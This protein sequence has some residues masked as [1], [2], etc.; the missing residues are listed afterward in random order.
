MPLPKRD[1][2]GRKATISMM[3][4][5]SKPGEVIDNATHG[6]SITIEKNGKAAAV[7]APSDPN[8][9]CTVI[10]GDGTIEGAIPLTFRRD[11][12]NGGYGE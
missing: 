12:G 3:E 11:L 6:M 10:R 4:F 9:D 8:N 5:R 1:Y 7:L 2:R